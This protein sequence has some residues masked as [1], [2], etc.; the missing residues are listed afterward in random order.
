MYA[1]EI[2]TVEDLTAANAQ[3]AQRPAFDVRVDGLRLAV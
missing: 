1:T 2:D 3:L